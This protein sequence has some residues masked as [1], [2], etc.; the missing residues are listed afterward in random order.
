MRGYGTGPSSFRFEDASDL[1]SFISNRYHCLQEAGD[2][3][4]NRYE[5]RGVEHIKD[6]KKYVKTLPAEQRSVYNSI[7]PL[8]DSFKAIAQSAD[9]WTLM[10][11][12]T[13]D[14]IKVETK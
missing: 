9:G 4:S 11:D 8:F 2:E 3:H 10:G 1:N 7:T 14:H 5:M 12:Y 6:W 13:F